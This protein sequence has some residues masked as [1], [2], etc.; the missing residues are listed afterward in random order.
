[1]RIVNLGILAHVDA[2]KTTLT[3]QLLFHAGVIATPGSVDHGTTQTDT[4]DLERERGITIQSA[5]VSF[6]LDDL[7]VNLIDT[8][9]HP[10]F[11]AEVERALGVLDAVVLVVSAVE[12]I[13][14]Q[15]RRLF[16]AVQARH[17]PCLIFVNK[18]DRVG[19]RA[20]VVIAELEADL[21]ACPVPCSVVRD[22][23]NR[24]ATSTLRDFSSPVDQEPVVNLLGRHAPSLIDSWAEHD[25]CLPGQLLVAELARQY[26]QG[27]LQPLV[28]GSAMTGEGVD[29]LLHLLTLV[30]PATSLAAP[31]ATLAAEVFKVQRSAAGERTVLARLHRGQLTMRETV[32]IV[33]P[34]AE[35]DPDPARITGLNV[36]RDGAAMQAISACPGNIVRL[37]GL[38]EARIGDWLGEVIAH[39]VPAFEPPVFEYQITPH[40]AGAQFA[41]RQALHHMADEDPLIATRIDDDG[42]TFIHIYGEVQ[43]QVIEWTLQ[44]RF[45]LAVTFSEPAVLCVERLCKPAAAAEIFGETDPPFYATVGFRIRPMV[46]SVPVWSYR[47]GKAKHNYFDAAEAGGRS[48]LA[49]GPHGWPIVDVDVEVTDLIYLNMSVP[50]DYR[51]LAMLVMADA[52]KRA[53]TQVCEPLHWFELRAPADAA[54]SCVHLLV[55]NQADILRSSVIDTTIRIEGTVP[56]ASVDTI[57]RSLPGQSNGR[58]DLDTRFHGYRPVTGEPPIRRRTGLDPYHR[59]QFLSRLGGR[60]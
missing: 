5:V 23:G 52:V 18:I 11:I 10:D 31:T 3:D 39:R 1:M 44:D 24:T 26:Q 4:L 21:M 27:V 14:S 13:Q 33:R 8:P 32:T 41:L 19:S 59:T 35:V 17:L 40:D 57:A 6:T 43:R 7:Q 51:R 16:R 2:G 50:A 15:T 45:G 56:A 28:C 58:G 38:P 53:G 9:G 37:H 54:G 34:H 12:G 36:F 25:G 22:E 47:P 20:A 48:T 55:A 49:A 30:V 29:Q 60:F 46:G 42:A